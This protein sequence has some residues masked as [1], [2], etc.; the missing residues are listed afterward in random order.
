MT[1]AKFTCMGVTKRKAWSGVD[2][3]FVYDAEFS[4]V[5]RHDTAKTREDAIENEA[6]W[7]AT[8][9]GSIKLS[10]L[11]ADHFEV[12]RDYYIDFTAVCEPA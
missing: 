1:R 5:T 11:R 8:P 12:G 2:G 10:T 7:V 6:F 3:A 4:A 9:S